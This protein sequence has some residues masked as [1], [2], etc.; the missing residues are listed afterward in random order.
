VPDRNTMIDG[1]ARAL[2]EAKVLV[3]STGAGISKESGI[4]TFRDAPNALWA[5]YDPEQL[6]TET[7]FRRDPALVWRWYADRRQ[8]ISAAK[9]NAGHTAIADL[10]RLIECVV[11]ITQNID[12]LHRKAG[13]SDLIEVHGNIFRFK[14]FDNHHPVQSLPRDDD[15]PPR[16]HCG[17]HIRPDVVWFGEMLPE[18][19]IDRAYAALQRCE[20]VLVVGTSGTVH[21]AAGFAAVAKDAG[22]RVIEVNPEH[23]PITGHADFFLQG[24][25]GEVLPQ[26]VRSLRSHR[27]PG[28]HS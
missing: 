25:A 4:P 8:M 9:P 14:C 7:G 5:N 11:V 23:T 28:T 21:P 20:V 22:A 24:P 6:A 27:K 2:G 17:S 12:D 18:D 1:C 13:S 26:L 10:E 15:V 16:C 19:E 3:V